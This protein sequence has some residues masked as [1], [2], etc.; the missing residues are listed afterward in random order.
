MQQLR[1]AAALLAAGTVL[2]VIVAVSSAGGRPAAPVATSSPLALPSPALRGT[3]SVE[4][5]LA[6]RR[7]VREYSAEDLTPA[8]IGQ[9]L[10]AAQGVTSEDGRR[11]APSA[12]ATYPLELYAVTAD[13]VRRYLPAEHA[14]EVIRSADVRVDLA[15]AAVGQTF[16]GEAPLVVVVTAVP[17]RTEVRYGA[18]AERYIAL[19]AGHAAQNLLLEAVALG[20]VSVPVGSF[21]DATVA[22]LVGLES[23]ETPL[24]LLPV[25]RPR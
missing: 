12:G 2:V 16:V 8:E 5:A 21:D 24:Y 15:R 7:S 22:K 13:G 20:L 10:W 9:L 14:L 17:E 6:G 3:V 23:G 4:E 18:R 1:T 19:E 11:T 25:G